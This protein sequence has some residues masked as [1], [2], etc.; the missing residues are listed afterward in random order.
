MHLTERRQE[1]KARNAVRRDQG[2]VSAVRQFDKSKRTQINR[3][4]VDFGAK[5]RGVEPHVHKFTD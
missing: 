3:E 5:Y 4:G 2:C 1:R